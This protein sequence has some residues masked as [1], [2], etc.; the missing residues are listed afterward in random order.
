MIDWFYEPTTKGTNPMSNLRL[1]CVECGGMYEVDAHDLEQAY[2]HQWNHT[3]TPNED[4]TRFN[5]VSLEDLIE[6]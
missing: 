1:V 3:D 2:E 4:L 5:L 6:P